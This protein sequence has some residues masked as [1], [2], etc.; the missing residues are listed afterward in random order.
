MYNRFRHIIILLVALVQANLVLAQTGMPDTVCI[1]T[2]RTYSV[3]TP[4]VPSTYTWRL[5]GVLQTS[6]SNQL[7][8]TWA[9]AGIYTI[10]V[11]EH[12]VVTGCEGDPRSGTVYVLAPPVANAGPDITACFG[13]DISL[14]G[15]GGLIYNWSPPV[16]LSSPFVANPRVVL[17]PT[18]THIYTLS[19]SNGVCASLKQDTV[20]V[21][22]TAA[23][24]VFAGNDT[25]IALNQPL[26]LNVV[27]VNN[28]GFVSWQWTPSFGLNNPGIKNP[29]A[30][31]DRDITYVVTVRTAE[32]CQGGD[33][34]RVKVFARAD[35]YVPTAFTPNNDGLNDKAV[36]IPVGIKELQYFTIFNR[37]GEVVFTTKDASKGWDGRVAGMEQPNAVFVWQAKG[38]DY[39]GNI[40]SREGTVTLIR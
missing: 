12:N 36:V 2:T 30:V 40:I 35:I 31:T 11:Q 22:I 16:Y 23:P 20:V 15:S 13:K 5:D 27:D 37:W 26:Q 17:A 38:I 6:S 8:V 29:V 9:A 10:T 18:G 14:S 34:I 19:V 21:K 1:G 25:S 4:A 7:R 33:D 28:A 24:K 39:K 3:N 32:G